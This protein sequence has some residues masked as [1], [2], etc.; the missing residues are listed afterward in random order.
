MPK[1]RRNR[2]L[3]PKLGRYALKL[4][5]SARETHSSRNQTR[6]SLQ[7]TSHLI[8]T[9]LA[10]QP[11]LAFTTQ[12]QQ[13]QTFRQRLSYRPT[14]LHQHRTKFNFQRVHQ[15]QWNRIL[16]RFYTDADIVSKHTQH[17]TQF[18]IDFVMATIE[19]P[20]H[21]AILCAKWFTMV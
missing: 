4:V 3:R 1:Y 10:S 5:M 17:S 20:T 21:I 16:D 8:H 14:L 2:S 19:Q 18:Y 9:T 13:F 12:R 15:I 11:F 7:S 6:P